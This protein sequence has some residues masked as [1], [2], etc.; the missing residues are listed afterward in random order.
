MRAA[1]VPIA[2]GLMAVVPNG[3][4]F[5]A[6][7]DDDT[8][9]VEGNWQDA[10]GGSGG[11]SGGS[12][13][14]AGGSG[15]SAPVVKTNCMRVDTITSEHGQ[16]TQCVW[17][18][19][20]APDNL[21][22]MWDPVYLEEYLAPDAPPPIVVTVSDLQ[23]LPILRGEINV[24]PPGGRALINAEVIG[25]SSAQAHVLDAVVMGANVQVR[26]TPVVWEWE[27]VGDDRGPFTTDHPGG[28]Y[29][30]M[31]V[32]GIYSTT[33]EDRAVRATITWMG[34]YRVGSGPW[35]LVNGNAVTTVESA[36]FETVEAPARLVATD[37]NGN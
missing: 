31:S 36:P 19:D 12:G 15:E 18:M 29:P 13:G 34:E 10:N 21:V 30:D 28:P 23:S 24:Q 32:N 5:G 26:L 1:L 22:S 33:G 35:L 14:S 20:G 7:F 9:F 8:A 17:D 3:A 2:I 11:D 25:Y 16:F 4:D 27:F 37:L 6:G